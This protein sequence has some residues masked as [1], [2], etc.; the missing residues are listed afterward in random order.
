MKAHFQRLSDYNDWA[1]K[2]TLEALRYQEGSNECKGKMSHILLAESVWLSRLKGISLTTN[3]FEMLSVERMEELRSE[4]SQG[5]NWFI[6]DI[7]NPAEEVEYKMLNGT[8]TK[9]SISD[10]L[11]HIFNHGTYHRAQIATLFRQEG[12][13]PVST[14]YISFS[15]L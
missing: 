8:D 3:I 9:S 2:R 4:N 12:K 14:D 7:E 15:R 1:N 11:T 6:T 5:W 13:T 10:V